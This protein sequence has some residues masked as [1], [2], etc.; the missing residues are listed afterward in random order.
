M[1]RLS[2][3]TLVVH[4]LF[5]DVLALKIATSLQWIEHTPQVIPNMD[6]FASYNPS[7]LTR[8]TAICHQELLQGR[9]PSPA[10][11]RRCSQPRKRQNH[12]PCGKRRD[13]G[14]DS[15]RQ[16][17]QPPHHLHHRRCRIPL[18][19]EQGLRYQD[20]RRLEGQA[21]WHSA[22]YISSILREQA[23]GDRGPQG[24]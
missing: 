13:T 1:H 12:R 9:Q 23:A 17:F 21:S 19:R 5:A 18:D 4:L 15:V 14:S 8:I 2:L 24:R 10:G 22:R 16:S 11:Q 3:L 20:A 7:S 6:L